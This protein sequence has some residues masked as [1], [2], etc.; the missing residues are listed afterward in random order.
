MA[1]RVHIK[2]I[3][4]YYGTLLVAPD[5][6]SGGRGS[7]NF[8]DV[9]FCPQHKREQLEK[10]TFEHPKHLH[11]SAPSS[12]VPT[13]LHGDEAMFDDALPLLGTSYSSKI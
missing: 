12:A 1:I 10:L 2:I 9:G 11:Y 7:L 3:Y 8:N 6:G 13:I 5:C 4:L